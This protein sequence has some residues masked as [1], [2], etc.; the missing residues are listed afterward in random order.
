MTNRG[1]PAKEWGPFGMGPWKGHAGVF[2]R[3]CGW[4]EYH[5][6]V[7]YEHEPPGDCPDGHSLAGACPRVLD[8]LMQNAWVREAL[9][10]KPPQAP[11]EMLLAVAGLSWEEVERMSDA[12]GRGSH[13]IADM[14]ARRLKDHGHGECQDKSDAD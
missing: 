8:R 3:V 10:G 14:R 1:V 4:P 11:M 12:N 2:C 6:W 5:L 13:S 7:D 9:G